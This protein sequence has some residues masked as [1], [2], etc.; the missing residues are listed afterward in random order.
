ME[1]GRRRCSSTRRELK[2]MAA[3]GKEIV[4]HLKGELISAAAVGSG[5]MGLIRG[6]IFTPVSIERGQR[7]KEEGERSRR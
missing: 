1:E 7:E 3:V 4:E 5:V 6:M 2:T